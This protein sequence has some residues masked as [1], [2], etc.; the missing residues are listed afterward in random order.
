MPITLTSLVPSG[1]VHVPM[2]TGGTLRLSPGQTSEQLPDAE[3][4]NNPTLDKLVDAGIVELRST[5]KPASR[6]KAA[7]AGDG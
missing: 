6:A 2:A 7:P 4:T 1:P 5:G 3:A